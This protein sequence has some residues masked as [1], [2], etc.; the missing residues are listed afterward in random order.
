MNKN[1]LIHILDLI[2]QFHKLFFLNLLA[3]RLAQTYEFH[4]QF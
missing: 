2:P 3:V 1:E 4:S